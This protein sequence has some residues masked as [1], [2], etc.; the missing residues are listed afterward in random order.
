MRTSLL[1]P[2]VTCLRHRIV[3]H[4]A[5]LRK[6]SDLP[7][8]KWCYERSGAS[9]TNKI[10]EGKLNLSYHA[11]PQYIWSVLAG[12]HGRPSGPH[13]GLDDGAR[14][15]VWRFPY[16]LSVVQD[17]SFS[18]VCGRLV[19]LRTWVNRS[20]VPWC[21]AVLKIF[22]TRRSP[23][24]RKSL[25]CWQSGV[26]LAFRHFRMFFSLHMPGGPYPEARTKRDDSPTCEKA[27]CGHLSVSS[28]H[29]D[30]CRCIVYCTWHIFRLPHWKILLRSEPRA[31]SNWSCHCWQLFYYRL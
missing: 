18:Q 13:D 2:H 10:R 3:G 21:C 14:E 31:H 27:P 16:F 11:S 29:G 23:R 8:R 25:P 28:L 7:Q 24:S 22:E 12:S 30:D 19:C 15:L 4:S 9:S 17:I 5:W 6:W 1:R 20:L 26:N